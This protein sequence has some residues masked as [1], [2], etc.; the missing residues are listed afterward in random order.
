MGGGKADRDVAMPRRGVGETARRRL[1]RRLL[2]GAALLVTTV[3]AILAVRRIGAGLIVSG[4]LSADPKLVLLALS[5]MC[6][7]MATRAVAW[8]AI[9][10]ATFP[11]A[12][13]ALPAV[14]R[15]TSIGVLL[16]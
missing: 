9:L 7:A 5:L 15:A 3:G 11:G 10:A 13:I 16:S 2:T 12:G 14:L 1:V 8:R 4:V 6:L